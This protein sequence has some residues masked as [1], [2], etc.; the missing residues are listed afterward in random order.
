[1]CDPAETK[2]H[3]RHH[4]QPGQPRHSVHPA[5]PDH[6]VHPGHPGHPVHPGLG[7]GDIIENI[8]D[9]RYISIFPTYR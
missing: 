9:S 3:P 6:P 8:I 7:V 1:M 4:R 5:H 2:G